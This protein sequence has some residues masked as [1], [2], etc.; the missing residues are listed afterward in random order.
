MIENQSQYLTQC[1][2][3]FVSA[4][5]LI[6]VYL[7]RPLTGDIQV[8]TYPGRIIVSEPKGLVQP[9]MNVEKHSL[10]HVVLNGQITL[11]CIAQGHPV[12]T[13]R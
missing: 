4:I 12:P 2:F 3:L 13:Y 11:P 1:L 6:F 8:S 7:R 9:R 5:Q 10:R